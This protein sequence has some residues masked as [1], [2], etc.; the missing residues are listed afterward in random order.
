[1]RARAWLWGVLLVLPWALGC[2]GVTLVPGAL[3]KAVRVESMALT[4]E[5]GGMGRLTLGLVVENPTLWDARVVGVDYEL[6]LDGRRYAVGTRGVSLLLAS[7]ARS[8]L[9]VSF[10]LRSAPTRASE[11]PPHLWQVEVRGGVR[12]AFGDTVRV[13]P[14]R[15]GTSLRLPFFR[16][17]EPAPE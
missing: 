5:P 14:L 1:M 2:A 15:T 10:P 12:L 7:G 13:L 16:P 3:D 9:P 8:V 11:V 4:F 6:L 17:L